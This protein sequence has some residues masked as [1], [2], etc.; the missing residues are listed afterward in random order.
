MPSH[1][2][3]TAFLSQIYPFVQVL[4]LA[5]PQE[6][7]SLALDHS[8]QRSIAFA[9]D[10]LSR[11][12]T[13]TLYILEDLQRPVLCSK[14]QRKLGMLHTKYPH[15]RINHISST[16]T[17]QPS[18]EQKKADLASL[19]GEVP[20]VFDGVCRVMTGPPCHLFLKEGAVPV[21]IRGSRPVSEPLRGPFKDELAAQV[22]QG[23]IRKVRPEEVTPWI[24]GVVVVPKKQGGNRFCHD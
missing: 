4:Q 8:R 14:T 24:H 2:H 11:P 22:K 17:S 23:I 12:V 3:S 19:M 9:E 1:T 15:A 5:P 13:T 10:G 7:P 18:E 20:L 21:K 6:T 16:P